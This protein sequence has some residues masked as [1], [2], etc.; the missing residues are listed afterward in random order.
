MDR[1][2]TEQINSAP[3]PLKGYIHDVETMYDP[4]GF[5]QERI[6]LRETVKALET[7]V[8]ELK[9]DLEQ[10]QNNSDMAS[11]PPGAS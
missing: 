6:C 11:S 9:Q 2:L 3:E 4:A 10:S 5:Q 7:L 1:T 8:V